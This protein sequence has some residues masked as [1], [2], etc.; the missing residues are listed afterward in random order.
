MSGRLADGSLAR[1]LS[2]RLAGFLVERN[3]VRGLRRGKWSRPCI[4][5]RGQRAVD[6][7]ERTVAGAE[8]KLRVHQHIEQRRA[9]RGV[10][11]PESSCLGLR[12]SQPWHF[13]EFALD[14]PKYVFIREGRV[15]LHGVPRSDLLSPGTVVKISKRCTTGHF[16]QT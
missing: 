1:F 10:K 8:Q 15:W 9:R 12:Q 11:S 14:S 16:G 6:P 13:E 7:H 2:S 5:L 4:C 3:L